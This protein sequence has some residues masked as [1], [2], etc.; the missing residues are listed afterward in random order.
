MGL[1]RQMPK[2]LTPLL[3]RFAIVELLMKAGFNPDEPRDWH[4]R[5]TTIGEGDFVPDE[6][7]SDGEGGLDERPP[8]GMKL[9]SGVMA[10]G[11]AAE[12]P[13]PETGKTVIFDGCC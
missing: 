6:S 3:R 12:L 4:G 5:W 2:D 1:P 11:P 9:P 10:F 8:H 7:E 13:N